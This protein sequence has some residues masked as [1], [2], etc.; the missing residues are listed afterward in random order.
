MSDQLPNQYSEDKHESTTVR[1]WLSA[2]LYQH[3]EHTYA[4]A[5]INIWHT[6]FKTNI[7]VMI[8]LSQDDSEQSTSFTRPKATVGIPCST[9]SVVIYEGHVLYP[10]HILC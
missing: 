6:V 5:Y 3:S 2:F 9:T 10:S 1:L 7:Y 4:S 8:L